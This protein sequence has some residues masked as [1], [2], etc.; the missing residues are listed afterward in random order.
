[1]EF[2]AWSKGTPFESGTEITLFRYVRTEPDEDVNTPEMAW[3]PVETAGAAQIDES[4]TIL[5][6]GNVPKVEGGLYILSDSNDPEA[7]KEGVRPF[8]LLDGAVTYY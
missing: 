8:V 1:M 6:F 3:V 7:L 5:R 4:S 2:A